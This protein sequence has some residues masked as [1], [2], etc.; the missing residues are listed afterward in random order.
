MDLNFAF[1]GGRL[2]A[3]PD[4]RTFD[5]G[6]RMSTF[7]VAVKSSTPRRRIDVLPVTFWDPP[8]HLLDH[9][10]TPGAEVVVYG[11]IQRRFRDGPDGRHSRL[12]LVASAMGIRTDGNAAPDVEG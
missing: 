4:H 9:R 12:E 1:I 11:S 10:I 7:L 2:A 8:D 5:S 3:P 6:T